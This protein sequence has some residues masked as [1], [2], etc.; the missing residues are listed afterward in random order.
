M[1]SQLFAKRGA[2]ALLSRRMTGVR[3]FS[4]NKQH[5][6]T[7]NQNPLENNWNNYFS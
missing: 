4:L 7:A 5:L 1:L 2:A 3:Y 6:Q